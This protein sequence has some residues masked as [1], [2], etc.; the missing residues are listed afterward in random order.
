M[1]GVF[2]SNFQAVFPVRRGLFPFVFAIVRIR[3]QMADIRDVHDMVDLIT[4]ELQ[5]S[6]QEILKN[7]RTQIAHVG[8]VIHRGPQQYMPTWPAVMG[9]KDGRNGCRIIQ[10][11]G[12]SHPSQARE[13]IRTGGQGPDLCP[14]KAGIVSTSGTFGTPRIILSGGRS[15]QSWK[16]N[17]RLAGVS[18]RG[19]SPPMGAL[20]W[21]GSQRHA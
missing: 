13:K 17:A 5:G 21:T 7:I 18:G 2:G 16:R 4:I 14:V 12:H 19:S 9:S 6:P 3:Y 15:R 10:S 20:M 8:E 1:Q 11:N